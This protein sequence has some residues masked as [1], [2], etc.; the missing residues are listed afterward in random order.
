V[1]VINHTLFSPIPFENI[2]NDTN[3][4]IFGL[5]TN[6]NLSDYSLL[7]IYKDFDGI[8]NH[9]FDSAY[10]SDSINISHILPTNI[11]AIIPDVN[12]LDSTNI[13]FIG[14][15]AFDSLLSIYSIELPPS[16][17][18][19]FERAFYGCN[20]LSAI[21]IPK[22]QFID[23]LAFGYNS[24]LYIGGFIFDDQLNQQLLPTCGYT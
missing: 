24:N 22:I 1:T 4:N 16:I 18:H 7:M 9:A 20:N 11:T 17:S 10:I 13:S 3:G 14:E 8:A 21:N 6:V 19:I 15:S 23:P 12:Y 2:L 5:T